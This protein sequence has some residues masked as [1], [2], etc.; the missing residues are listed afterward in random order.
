MKNTIEAIAFLS[1]AAGD[2][3]A[4]IDFTPPKGKVIGCAIYKNAAANPG[5]VRAIIKDNAG[6]E[7]S[8]LQSIDNYRSRECEYLKGVKPLNIETLGR[9]FN[10]EV[11]ATQPF[12]DDFNAELIFVYEPEETC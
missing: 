9:T 8:K 11:I 5:F 12:T 7:I 6:L 1:I 10:F 4:N 3:T 2:T